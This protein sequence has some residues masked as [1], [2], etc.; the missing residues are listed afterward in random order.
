MNTVCFNADVRSSG[1]AD[2]RHVVPPTH[3]NPTGYKG[4]AQ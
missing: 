2:E 3:R 4:E 1:T